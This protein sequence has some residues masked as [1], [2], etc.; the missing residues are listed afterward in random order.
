MPKFLADGKGAIAN[1]FMALDNIGRLLYASPPVTA[2][3]REPL[4]VAQEATHITSSTGETRG[5]AVFHGADDNDAF[6]DL[7]AESTVRTPMRIL[8]QCLIAST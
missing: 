6:L 7:M 3:C 1:L 8:A 5:G 4:D 2:P